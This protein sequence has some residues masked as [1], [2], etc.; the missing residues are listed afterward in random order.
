MTSPKRRDIFNA[1]IRNKFPFFIQ[2]CC[3]HL[4]SG[5]LYMPN[6]HIGAI[7]YS[8]ERCRLLE[9]KRLII[10]LPPRS[11]KS[12]CAS[13]AFPAFILGHDPT[14]RILCVS[15]SSELALKHARYF[16]M[17]V[18]SP[19]YREVFPGMR[20]AKDTGTE[21]ETTRGGGRLAVSVGGSI[22]GRGGNY[23]IIDDPS[24]AEE[25]LS[26]ATRDKV[27]EYPGH[28]LYSRLDS[29]VDGVIVLVMQRLHEED[30]AGYLL[31]QGG[32]T[33][34]NLP[35]IATRDERIDLGDGAF[36]DRKLGDV[37]HPDREPRQALDEVKNMLGSISR[38]SISNPLSRK[39]A[40]SF[41][42]TGSAGT[43]CRPHAP[44]P[45]GSCRVGTTL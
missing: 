38:R 27:N 24:K 31:K 35:A 7:A 18:N 19:W 11:L 13:I 43:S 20:T 16:R 8:L 22:T 32:W 39:R 10:T 23:I 30:L 17:V 6:Y 12:I 42:G 34:L 37:L 2:K 45:P 25:A 41:S 3:D 33:H 36:H 29:K 15:Y 40:T 44:A 9:D 5:S 1:L 26:R 28:T 4:N 14:Q 21:F